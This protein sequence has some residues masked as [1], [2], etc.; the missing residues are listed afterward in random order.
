M[1]VGMGMM[2]VASEQLGD[3]VARVQAFGG[4][5]DSD[6]P[7]VTSALTF[8]LVGTDSRSED[9]APGVTADGSR[10]AAEVVMVAHVAGDRRSA[11]V[12]S[13]PR[14]SWVDIPGR[15]PGR[16][17]G[18]YTAGGPSLLIR[19]VEQLTALRIDHFAIIDFAGFRSMVDTVGGVDIE[20]AA[21]A[22]SAAPP[23]VS[24][25]NGAQALA[26][27]RDGAGLNTGD[28]A[29]R[30]Q[31]TLRA[32]MEKAASGDTLTDPVRLYD[33][34]D[35]TSHSVG[36]DET[37]NNGGLR[38]LAFG[39]SELHPTKVLFLRTPVS[40]LGR[41]AGGAVAQLDAARTPELWRAV[42]QGPVAGYVQQNGRDTL[43]PLTR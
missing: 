27:L 37:L 39:L 9:T 30:Q 29:R 18:A 6:R 35:A 22:G 26:Y 41:D 11:T 14:E 2:Y 21:P 25:M 32:M 24:H 13:I 20:T 42:E 31:N 23:R 43:G 34:L 28:R 15:G 12:V 7:P 19:T 5:D 4:L 36:V 16:V 38:A 3:N 1:A 17:S 33:F 10:S 8:L 40:G